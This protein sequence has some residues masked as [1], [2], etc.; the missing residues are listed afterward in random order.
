MCG[1]TVM[2]T[3]AAVVVAAAAI[4][5]TGRRRIRRPIA[6]SHVPAKASVIRAGRGSGPVRLVPG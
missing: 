4:D 2:K 3:V 5:T 1:A 6:C